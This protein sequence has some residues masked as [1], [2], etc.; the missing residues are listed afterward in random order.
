MGGVILAFYLYF[1]GFPDFASTITFNDAP[2]TKNRMTKNADPKAASP[3]NGKAGKEL[4]KADEATVLAAGVAATAMK[5][6]GVVEADNFVIEPGR[7]NFDSVV[8]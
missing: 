4:E 8:T 6:E 5:D 3:S 2:E 7:W 1:N